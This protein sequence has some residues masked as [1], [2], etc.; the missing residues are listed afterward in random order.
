[1]EDRIKSSQGKTDL[2][3]LTRKIS[4]NVDLKEDIVFQLR[5]MFDKLTYPELLLLKS[6]T[7]KELEKRKAN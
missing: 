6:L 1:M 5:E 2:S 7:S 4:K 3:S